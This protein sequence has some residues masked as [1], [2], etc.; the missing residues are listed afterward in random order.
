MLEKQKVVSLLR[1]VCT[2]NRGRSK[3]RLMHKQMVLN[4]E[5]GMECPSSQ[6]E[7]PNEATNATK[8]KLAA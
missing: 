8:L 6:K 3:G 5:D 7:S 4:N 1:T 2:F